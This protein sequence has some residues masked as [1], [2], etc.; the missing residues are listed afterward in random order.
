[1]KNIIFLV[2]H[3]TDDNER[4]LAFPT[5]NRAIKE[6]SEWAIEVSRDKAIGFPEYKEV[7]KEGDPE[8]TVNLFNDIRSRES[9]LERISV[10]MVNFIEE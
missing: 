6:A 8:D 3:Q 2:C 5:Y 9:G 10:Y 4:F 1:M 7:C